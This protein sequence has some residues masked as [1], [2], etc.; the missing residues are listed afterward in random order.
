[1]EL[2]CDTHAEKSRALAMVINTTNYIMNNGWLLIDAN[3]KPTTW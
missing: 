3:G 2:V 1:M